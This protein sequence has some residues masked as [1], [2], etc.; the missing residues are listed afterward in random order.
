MNVI[1]ELLGMYWVMEYFTCLATHRGSEPPPCR[2]CCL[3][4]TKILWPL[5][6]SKRWIE[7]SSQLEKIL[8]YQSVFPKMLYFRDR[9]VGNIH[10]FRP[11]SPKSTHSRR[12]SSKSSG[13]SSH[14]GQ[15]VYPVFRTC[16]SDRSG[17]SYGFEMLPE[18]RLCLGE[19]STRSMIGRWWICVSNF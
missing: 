1:V 18:T 5:G 19:A 10:I 3:V 4:I 6:R 16:S 12:N 13:A 11:S 17:V 8:N 14:I 7:A 2:H 15:L 9:D